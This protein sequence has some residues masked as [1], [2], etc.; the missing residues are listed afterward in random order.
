[1]KIKIH[2]FY[3]YQ[4]E[5]LAQG[6]YRKTFYNDFLHI[7]FCISFLQ[8]SYSIYVILRP[9]ILCEEVGTFIHFIIIS[10]QIDFLCYNLRGEA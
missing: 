4:K 9:C 7:D 6:K 2:H 3:L 1:M 10:I 5:H 8:L